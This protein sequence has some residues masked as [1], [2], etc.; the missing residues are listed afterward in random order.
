[1]EKLEKVTREVLDEIGFPNGMFGYEDVVIAVKGITEHPE[2]A[3]TMCG[4]KG[5]YNYISKNGGSTTISRVERN[6]RVA[7]E[8]CFENTNYD[9]ML[10]YMNGIYDINK[11]KAVNRNF[12]NRI[13]NIVKIRTDE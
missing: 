3:R 5:L 9:V 7:I 8:W 10:K 13:A 1:M 6:I 11:G 4:E 12:V 2:I